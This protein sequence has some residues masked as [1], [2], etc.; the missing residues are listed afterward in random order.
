MVDVECTSDVSRD[1]SAVY[2]PVELELLEVELS[3][4]LLLLNKQNYIQGL[5]GYPII[6][7]I[8]NGYL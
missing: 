6:P 8:N 2:F 5:A 3:S 1:L 4:S 7:R